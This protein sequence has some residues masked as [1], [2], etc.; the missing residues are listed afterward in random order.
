LLDTTSV[1]KSQPG[2]V[3]VRTPQDYLDQLVIQRH[4]SR[5]L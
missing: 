4:W 1:D 2:I 5:Q 3:E